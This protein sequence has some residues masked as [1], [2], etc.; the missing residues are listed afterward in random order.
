MKA[1]VYS[2]AAA[3]KAFL[4]LIDYEIREMVD[5]NLVITSAFTCRCGE[6]VL[7]T[8]NDITDI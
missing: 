2:P 4:D 6:N 3:A 1:L 7:A 8:E 5:D